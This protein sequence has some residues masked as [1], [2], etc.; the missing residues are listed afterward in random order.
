M[1]KITRRDFLKI[2]GSYFAGSLVSNN[3]F[4]LTD[5]K[6]D[7]PN[8]IIILCDALSARHLSLYGY[9]R[10]TTPYIDSFADRSTVYHQHYS[11]GNFT[12]TGT[13]S[14]LT[15]MFGWKHRAINQGG[16]VLPE[17]TSISPYSL[18]GADYYKFAFSQNPWSDRLVGQNYQDVD[19]FLPVT[20]YSLREENLITSIFKNDHTIA[21]IAVDDFLLPLQG[22]T[23]AGSSIV[24]SYYKKKAFDSFLKEKNNSARYPNGIP[25]ILIGGYVAPYL[26]EDVYNGVYL[27]LSQ[28]E[29][30]KSPYFA[31][32]HL[33]SP[34]FPYNPRR[35]Y[36]KLFRDDYAPPT[37]P[38]HPLSPKFH[39]E[40]LLSR[41]TAYDRQIAQIDEEF[42]RLIAKLDKTGVLA[43]SYLIFT[44]DHGE[45]FERGFAGHG[46]HFMYESVLQV[47]LLIHAPGQATRSDIFSPTSNA[48]LLPTLLSITG[49]EIPSDVDG[50]V[51]PSFGGTENPDRPIFSVYAVDNSAFGPMKKAVIAMRKGPYKLIAYLG[52]ENFDQVFELYNLAVD[53]EELLDLSTK[54]LGIFS[55]L[56]QEFYFNLENANKPFIKK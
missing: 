21:S 49:K 19:N 6:N 32:F 43:N 55:K 22:D 54:E 53:P 1:T 2:A 38:V 46:F 7:P 14:L 13:A 12:T 39:D 48:D 18:L 28:L 47:P 31:F 3:F 5:G 33:F 44:S 4:S 23:A 11:G 41:R 27:E 56:K 37:K 52:Y 51:L 24:G 15:G 40:F 26:N 42:G 50:V 20:A 16:L 25:E 36:L 45:L 35:E 10:S 34:H 8:I 29:I 30:R 9:P 17:F